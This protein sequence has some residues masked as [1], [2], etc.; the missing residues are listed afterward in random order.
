MIMHPAECAMSVLLTVVF[1]IFAIILAGYLCGRSKVLGDG[2]AEGLNKFVY[3][4]ALPA[5]LFKA[6]ATVDMDALRNWDFLGAYIGGQ[7]ITM[8]LAMAAG[9][10]LFRN[11]IAEAG[12][13][14]MNGIYGNTGFLGIPLALSAF[15]DA[16]TVPTIITVI[17]NSALVVAV[18]VVI[19]EMGESKQAKPLH[20]LK[21]VGMALVKNPML[22]APVAGIIWA[23]LPIP[24][25]EALDKF[26]T[27][28]GAAAGPCALF[29]IGLF[30]VGK[31]ITQGMA[32][33]STGTLIKLIVQP[34]ITWLLIA[35]V[36]AVPPLWAAV[37]VLMAAT[38][39]GAGSFV[40]A[41]QYNL[42]VQRTSSVILLSTIGSVLTIFLLLQHYNSLLLP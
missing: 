9:M 11:S 4:V 42:Y 23:A 14:G 12:M 26:C 8:A 36:F 19:I 39:T 38:P 2:S 41:Q 18:A 21:D 40:L 22:I 35:Y 37:A 29:A 17:V 5:L 1:P 27:L 32:E 20:V 31:P 33:V 6:M 25:P 24:F 30:L 34:A 16:A 15:G 3:W 10:L 28:L 7:A 13:N